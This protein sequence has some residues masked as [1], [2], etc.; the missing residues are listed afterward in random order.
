M[1]ILRI[2]NSEPITTGGSA[3]NI[4][5][6]ENDLLGILAE[7]RKLP[8]ET[9]WAEFKHNNA[10]EKERELWRVF[11]RTPFE[12]EVAAENIAAEK[13]RSA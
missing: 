7:L 13:V 1:N 2:N 12:K 10:P 5:R 4:D 6:P 9:E 11:D 8:K 3:V